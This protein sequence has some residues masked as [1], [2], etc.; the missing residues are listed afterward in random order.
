[1]YDIIIVGSGISGLYCAYKLQ[2]RTR[3]ICILEKEPSIGGRIQTIQKPD[4]SRFEVGADCFH[5]RHSRLARLLIELGIARYKE[6]VHI[7]TCFSRSR[8]QIDCDTL[9]NINPFELLKPIYKAARK[10]SKYILQ[11]LTFIDFV[12]LVISDSKIIKTILEA[13]SEHELVINMNAYDAINYFKNFESSNRFYTLKNGMSCIIDALCE[14]IGDIP[15][16][17]EHEVEHI[18]HYPGTTKPK[19]SPQHFLIYVKN[20]K[21][22]FLARNCVCALPKLALEKLSIFNNIHSLMDYV[23]VRSISSIYAMFRKRDTWFTYFPRIN[24]E[25]V[26]NSIVPID[27]SKGLIMLS[28]TDNVYNEYWR[29]L[30]STNDNK[31]FI[32]IQ[33]YFHDI[34]NF[35]IPVPKWMDY[36]HWD[37]GMGYWKPGCNSERISQYMLNPYGRDVP[38]YVCGENFSVKQGWIEGALETSNKIVKI[39]E[40]KFPK[41]KS[42]LSIN[43]PINNI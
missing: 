34:F 36:Y 5:N 3:N 13:L 31:I 28:R 29:S 33:E 43:I 10:N 25:N 8:E 1:M 24:T 26:L 18:V 22:P 4:G 37:T 23:G 40:M 16:Y 20:R 12:S 27:S 9:N 41:E 39:L 19:G 42:E 38:L 6:R 17:T 30:L 32:H 35:N 2:H 7:N 11:E 14:D 21:E 15:I